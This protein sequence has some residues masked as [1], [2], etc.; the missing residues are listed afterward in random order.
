MTKKL[1]IA[2]SL[3]NIPRYRVVKKHFEQQSVVI[4]YDWSVHGQVYNHDELR[5]YGI[6]EEKGVVEAHVLLLILPGRNGAH[7]EMG[8]ARSLGI[9]IVILEEQPVEQK[10]FYYIP[11]LYKTNNLIDADLCV[12]TLLNEHEATTRGLNPEVDNLKT[13]SAISKIHKFM[14]Q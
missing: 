14:N 9:P 8:M 11:G 2:T 6:E 7:Y 12:M 3:H 10:T 1:Y 5:K 4:T 13:S